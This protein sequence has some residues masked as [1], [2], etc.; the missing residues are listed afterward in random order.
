[1]T[2]TVRL[3]PQLQEQLERHCRKRRLT[4]SEVVT[5]LLREHLAAGGAQDK[6][7]YALARQFGLVGAFAS[8]RRDVAENRKRYLK[9]KLRAKHSR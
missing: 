5:R 4:K 9:Q 6:T 7:P 1:M 3:D 2:I 8:G